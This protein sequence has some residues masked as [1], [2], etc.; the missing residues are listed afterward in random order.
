MRED[1]D[2]EALPCF[3]QTDENINENLLATKPEPDD[4]DHDVKQLLIT[5]PAIAELLKNNEKKQQKRPHDSD[6]D[7][8]R[9]AVEQPSFKQEESF[10]NMNLGATDTQKGAVGRYGE[11]TDKS[12]NEAGNPSLKMSNIYPDGAENSF[13]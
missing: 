5:S 4:I 9:N 11:M 12:H 3:G 6:D 7:E 13:F 10:V 2:P 8:L 1:E